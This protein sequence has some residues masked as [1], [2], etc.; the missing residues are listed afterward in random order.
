MC[1]SSRTRKPI[2]SSSAFTS[3]LSGPRIPCISICARICSAVSGE[4]RSCATIE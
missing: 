3:S 4:R 2:F 1:T